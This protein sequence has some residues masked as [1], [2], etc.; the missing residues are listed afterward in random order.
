VNINQIMH[1]TI[2][3]SSLWSSLQAATPTIGYGYSNLSGSYTMNG[4]N[5]V[6]GGIPLKNI[7]SQISDRL[8]ILQPDPKKLE[9]YEAL[10][11]AYEHFKTLEALLKEDENE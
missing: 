2:S 1:S 9:K 6:V 11:I 8:L 10:R 4:D 7:L 3:T 5:I